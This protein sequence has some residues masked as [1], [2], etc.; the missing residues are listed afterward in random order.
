M[1][2]ALEWMGYSSVPNRRPVTNKRPWWVLEALHWHF[3][4]ATGFLS[5]DQIVT[6]GEASNQYAMHGQPHLAD[7][8]Y[9]PL[10]E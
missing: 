8:L 5:R 9:V 3:T 1:W 2:F 4:L 7:I 6:G 10:V